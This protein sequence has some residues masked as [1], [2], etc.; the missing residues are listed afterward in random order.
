MLECRSCFHARARQQARP[1]SMGPNEHAARKSIVGHQPH[2]LPLDDQSLKSVTPSLLRANEASASAASKPGTGTRI[3]VRC[4]ACAGSAPFAQ[5]RRP[6]AVSCSH[7][8]S[9]HS[10]K[11]GLSTTFMSRCSALPLRRLTRVVTACA[12]TWPPS[13][14]LGS[15]TKVMPP[16]GSLMT[17]SQIERRRGIGVEQA[18]EPET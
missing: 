16:L 15:W 2:P 12:R 11:L 6:A 9:S 7:A 18:S 14:F 8:M 17:C 4:C 5:E 1:R 10:R 13:G 3:G